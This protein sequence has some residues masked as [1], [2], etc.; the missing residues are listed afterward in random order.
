MYSFETKNETKLQTFYVDLVRL[1]YIISQE[2]IY[3]AMGHHVTD[4]MHNLN[5][6]KICLCQ[7]CQT[8]AFSPQTILVG[9]HGWAAI[10]EN[11]SSQIFQAQC[12]E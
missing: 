8:Q 7:F 11:S 6:S 9:G 3:N 10:K 1:K 5:I 2:A 4:T 12:G